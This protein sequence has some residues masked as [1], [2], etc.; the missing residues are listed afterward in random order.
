M[1]ATPAAQVEPELAA[2]LVVSV[3]PQ[4]QMALPEPPPP[5]AAMAAMVVMV[6]VRSAASQT[7]W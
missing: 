3:E 4:A 5:V 7:L 6:G 2:Q 1:A